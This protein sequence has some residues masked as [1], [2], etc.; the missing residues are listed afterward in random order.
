MSDIKWLGHKDMQIA[1]LDPFA[2]ISGDMLLGALIDSGL[3]PEWLQGLPARQGP[4]VCWEH[5]MM[6]FL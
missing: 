4:M 3:D 6:T 2:G 5:P 1:I